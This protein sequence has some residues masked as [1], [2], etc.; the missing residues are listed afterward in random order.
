MARRGASTDARATRKP[1]LQACSGCAAWRVAGLV[2]REH[3]A[4][5]RAGMF[6]DEVD[7]REVPRG[8]ADLKQCQMAITAR[9]LEPAPFDDDGAVALGSRTLSAS[10]LKS[11]LLAHGF[12]REQDERR[13]WPHARAFGF[14]RRHQVTANCEPH[15]PLHPETGVKPRF[16]TPQLRIGNL[17]QQP[18]F[19]ANRCRAR[20]WA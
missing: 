19:S 15:P 1:L 7:L 3:A 8:E 12:L 18:R 20:R 17:G 14:G 11:G 13:G 2:L 16:S 10:H 9:Y 6:V 5:Q 4:Q